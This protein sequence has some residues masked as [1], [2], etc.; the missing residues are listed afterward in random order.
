M[1]ALDSI[2]TAAQATPRE[3]CSLR[4][5]IDSKRNR[6]GRPSVVTAMRFSSPSSSSSASSASL[7]L[8]ED[9]DG[10]YDFG[11]AADADT[12]SLTDATSSSQPSSSTAQT[13]TPSLTHAQWVHQF[14]DQAQRAHMRTIARSSNID[15]F[16]AY[17][18]IEYQKPEPAFLQ[19]KQPWLTPFRRGCVTTDP[20]A[21]RMHAQSVVAL[22][23]WDTDGLLELANKVVGRASEGY[24]EELT[25]LAPFVRDITDCLV[26]NVGN[27]EAE[28]F[29]VLVCECLLAEFAVWWDMVSRHYSRVARAMLIFY[30][31]RTCRRP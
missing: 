1:A 24:T 28:L 15:P 20:K 9:E 14:A 25:L 17:P 21:R 29:R 5:N 2:Y 18:D 26:E 12:D 13:Q 19:V 31:C 23:D 7:T 30:P 11:K 4:L 10:W 27:V 16:A 22:E 8:Y 6:W 3:P